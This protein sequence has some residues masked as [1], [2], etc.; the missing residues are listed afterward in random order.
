MFLHLEFL[1]KDSLT[2]E[3]KI[4][5]KIKR[6]KF[7]LEIYCES[8]FYK[9]KI[10]K[11]KKIIKEFSI[12]D[13]KLG[14]NTS[15]IEIKSFF[16]STDLERQEIILNFGYNGACCFIICDFEK[17]NFELL[18]PIGET[19]DHFSMFWYELEDLLL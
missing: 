2:K 10:R 19:E 14:N 3:D 4:I 5:F 16:Y 11:G 7:S 6:A 12:S 17:I 8:N 13:K 1:G 15:A 9:F 18:N